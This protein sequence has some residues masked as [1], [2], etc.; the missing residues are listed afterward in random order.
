MVEEELVVE[1]DG[2][3]VEEEEESES[4]EGQRSP[5]ELNQDRYF[6]DDA[7]K[8]CQRCKK[9]G[10]TRAAC[11]ESMVICHYCLGSHAK[12]DCRSSCCFNCGA[13]DHDRKE[14]RVFRPACNRCRKKGH[15]GRN[16]GF[17]LN[18]ELDMIEEIDDEFRDRDNNIKCE[19][20]GEYEHFLCYPKRKFPTKQKAMDY[21]KRDG[22]FNERY[23]K[24]LGMLLK[25][26]WEEEL[27]KNVPVNIETVNETVSVEYEDYD[28]EGSDEEQEKR[29]RR[30]D[31]EDEQSDPVDDEDHLNRNF[32][33][34]AS[35]SGQNEQGKR[36][37]FPKPKPSVQEDYRD[38]RVYASDKNNGFND[39]KQQN[40]HKHKNK[41]YYANKESQTRQLDLQFSKDYEL[42]RGHQNHGGRQFGRVQTEATYHGPSH[43]NGKDNRNQNEKVKRQQAK[44][45]DYDDE[46]EYEKKHPNDES[47]LTKS[48]QIKNEDSDISLF[49]NFINSL[50]TGLSKEEMNA[51]MS[52]GPNVKQATQEP[53][54]RTLKQEN[55][56]FRKY[57]DRVPNHTPQ[58]QG[59]QLLSKSDWYGPS[60]QQPTNAAIA[61]PQTNTK[62]N[63][64]FETEKFAGENIAGGGIF[65]SKT[66]KDK[67]DAAERKQRKNDKKL[68]NAEKYRDR[69]AQKLSGSGI[70]PNEF[71]DK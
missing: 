37:Q 6:F 51:A 17:L 67:I 32:Q 48:P 43:H 4:E 64:Q 11:T 62:R 22:L 24:K 55:D 31:I 66:P 60:N 50:R 56:P 61:K 29:P 63:K 68:A 54:T 34:A 36:D 5:P 16:C 52:S 23:R 18:R 44:D 41:D 13:L 57:R 1:F 10:H 9:T 26:D 42:E 14:C 71:D 7:K 20:C 58:P 15:L 38:N 47:E 25:T 8:V 49:G 65:F 59:P 70:D 30:K 3:P 28:G 21:Y 33:K 40:A 53:K 12:K 35:S 39:Q 45:V 27:K 19:L 46:V 2:Q 69:I